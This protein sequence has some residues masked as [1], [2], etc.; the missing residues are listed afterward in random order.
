MGATP[1]VSKVTYT[2]DLVLAYALDCA[3][4]PSINDPLIAAI[5]RQDIP[6]VATATG[7]LG[8]EYQTQPEI[9]LKLRQVEAF[10][11]KNASFSDETETLRNAVKS[12]HRSERACAI[13][14]K[15]LQ[16]FLVDQRDRCDFRFPGMLDSIRTIRKCLSHLLGDVEEFKCGLGSLLRITPGATHDRS[17]ARSLPFLKMTAKVRCPR[18]LWT[19]VGDTLRQLGFDESISPLR[20]VHDVTN[21]VMFVLKNYATKRTIAG[22]PT[23]SMPFQLA[24]DAWGKD[25][26]KR[27]FGCDLRSQVKSQELA[28]R[29]SLD[30]SWTT[31]DIERASD[32]VAFNCVFLLFPAPW[33]KLLLAMRSSEYVMRVEKRVTRGTYHKFSSMGN[34]CTFVLETALFAAICRAAGSTDH[35][36]Y[37][38]DICVR[39]QYVP[40]TLDLL[41]FL[42]FRINSAKSFHTGPDDTHFPFRESCGADWFNGRWVTPVYVRKEPSSYADFHHLINSMVKI[43]VP[44]GKVW[45]LCRLYV[46]ENASH[47]VPFST[48]TQSGVHVAASTAYDLGLVKM[49][50]FGL[51][52]PSMSPGF[53]TPFYWGLS[54]ETPPKRNAFGARSYYTWFIR[55]G[56]GVFEGEGQVLIRETDICDHICHPMT[57]GGAAARYTS[58]QLYNAKIDALAGTLPALSR[59]TTSVEETC[60]DVSKTYRAMRMVY[61]PPDLPVSD[62]LLLW[63]DYIRPTAKTV[64]DQRRTSRR[65]P[66]I[67]KKGQLDAGNLWPKTHLENDLGRNPWESVMSYPGS[68]P[69]PS[70]VDILKAADSQWYIDAGAVPNPWDGNSDAISPSEGVQWIPDTD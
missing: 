21:R 27:V 68:S 16:Y 31:L 38:D 34:G 1:S 37:G 44:Y 66:V 22:E 19:I 60:E 30:G 51:D 33:V 67:P 43:A 20:Y 17:R 23:H 41:R 56:G 40:R 18:S 5:I 7:F 42:G 64:V 59:I 46:E 11:K 8:S 2:W 58:R 12:F 4:P 15:R 26:L 62:E 63:S 3:F 54:E 69:W 52:K 65:C 29:G 70:A 49:S 9:W 13:T 48:S 10:V 45:Q 47:I 25:A 35:V 50:T 24:F 53:G 61:V 14:N 57:Y 6:A 55:P 32:T 28:R 36:V 39:S